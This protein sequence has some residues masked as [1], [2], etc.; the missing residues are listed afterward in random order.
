MERLVGRKSLQ[1]LEKRIVEAGVREVDG[2]P[3]CAVYN[4]SLEADELPPG[5]RC[6]TENTIS[7]CQH[8]W[9]LA[10]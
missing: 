8:A 6:V 1:R 7:C 3:G 2:G 5:R 4:A 9:C 10:A